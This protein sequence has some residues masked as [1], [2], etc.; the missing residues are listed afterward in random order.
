MEHVF[1]SRCGVVT[2]S[3]VLGP[4]KEI[5]ARWSEE[6]RQKNAKN[7]DMVPLNLRV[8]EGVE[9]ND[10][11]ITIEDSIGDPPVYTVD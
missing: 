2:H 7:F 8:F 10:L 3:H 6:V 9:W 4:P 1:C 11:K 5:Q